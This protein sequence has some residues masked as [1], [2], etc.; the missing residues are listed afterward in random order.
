MKGG[1]SLL[2]PRAYRIKDRDARPDPLTSVPTL[3]SNLSA[4]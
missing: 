2:L 4:V 3:E 1:G